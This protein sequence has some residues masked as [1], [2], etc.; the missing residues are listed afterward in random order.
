MSAMDAL[1]RKARVGQ[2]LSAWS[3]LAALAW[4]I[5]HPGATIS[6]VERAIGLSQPTVSYH[7]R[8][9]RDAGLVWAE[10]DA[11]SGMSH[12]YATREAAQLLAAL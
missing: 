4:V 10:R 5:D 6:E 7:L 12:Q 1:A 2:A 8:L 9:L 3:R 11:A